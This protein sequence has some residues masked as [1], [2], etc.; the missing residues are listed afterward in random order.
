[1]DVWR[2]LRVCAAVCEQGGRVTVSGLASLVRGLGGGSFPVVG[3]SGKGRGK[4]AS[5]KG[6]VDVVN[7][8]GDK[9]SLSQEQTEHLL[10]ELILSDYLREG[11]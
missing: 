3:L 11:W 4:I 5:E 10:I 8:G 7:L 9:V 6:R 2:I 1:V